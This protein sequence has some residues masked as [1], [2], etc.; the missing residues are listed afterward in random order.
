MAG[1]S[2]ERL[3]RALDQGRFEWSRHVRERLVERG[4]SQGAIVQALAA[5]TIIEDYA[6]NE[7][8]P[9][10][11]FLAWIEGQPVHVVAAHDEET[12]WAFIVTVYRPDEDRF[13]PDY[14]T[15]RR[16]T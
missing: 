7:P 15:R 11:L 9:S 5:G 16:A 10:A 14:A 8:Y 12:D 2:H 13:G 1:L 4:L 6:Y 3:R